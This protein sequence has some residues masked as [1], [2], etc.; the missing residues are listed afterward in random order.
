M[1]YF[2]KMLILAFLGLGLLVVSCKKNNVEDAVQPQSKP[3]AKVSC[4]NGMLVF[5]TQ[6]DFEQTISKVMNMTNEE[7]R[8]WEE[9]LGFLSQQRIADQINAAEIA[10]TKEL[11]KGID[12]NISLEEFK[13][14]GLYNKHSD[15]YYK[16]IKKGIIK[17][18][19]EKDGA[20]SY[21]MTICE[22]IMAIITNDEGL[23]QVGK[24]MYQYLDNTSKKL[25]DISKCNIDDFKSATI[26]DKEKGIYIMNEN[27]RLNYHSWDHSFN[28]EWRYH[29][30]G[31]IAFDVYGHSSNTTSLLS[32]TFYV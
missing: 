4:K 21:D 2:S 11:C 1:K 7:R 6:S 15:L 14:L 31:R 9:K 23:V 3:T 26:T 19:I 13:K 20:V 30:A 24:S 29:Q 27:T 16:Y 5:N 8:V 12:E 28:K 32:C 22:P 18:I 25:V 17:G 10:F